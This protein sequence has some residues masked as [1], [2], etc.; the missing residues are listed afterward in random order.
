ML[1]L[2]CSMIPGVDHAATA[3]SHAEG[4]VSGKCTTNL[5]VPAARCELGI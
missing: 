4:L 2:I 5:S 1:Y 3:V